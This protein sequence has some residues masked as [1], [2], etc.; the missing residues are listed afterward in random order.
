[1][2]PGRRIGCRPPGDPRAI[3]P[4]SLKPH[5]FVDGHDPAAWK[6]SDG[7]VTVVYAYLMSAFYASAT[8]DDGATWAT[9]L[10]LTLLGTDGTPIN[11]AEAGD[12]ALLRVPGGSYLLL[13]N[14]SDGL[15]SFRPDLARR[16]SPRRS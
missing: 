7:S 6:E 1:M 15:R 14:F 10:D 16:G 8:T 9:P 4:T 3:Q 13:S 2:R 11:T 12:V 5:V